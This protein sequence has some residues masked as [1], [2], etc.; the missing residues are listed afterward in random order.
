[1]YERNKKQESTYFGCRDIMLLSASLLNVPPPSPPPLLSFP[2][3]AGWCVLFG[4]PYK[5]DPFNVGQFDSD[6]KYI[7]RYNEICSNKSLDNYPYSVSTVNADG[8]VMRVTRLFKSKDPIQDD[9]TLEDR[10]ALYHCLQQIKEDLKIFLLP[11]F[12]TK[13]RQQCINENLHD[14]NGG[15]TISDVINSM[16]RASLTGDESVIKAIKR[17]KSGLSDRAFVR[18]SVAEFF[19]NHG[20]KASITNSKISAEGSLDIIKLRHRPH[21]EWTGHYYYQVAMLCVSKQLQRKITKRCTEARLRRGR[22][23]TLGTSEATDGDAPL[24]VDNDNQQPSVPFVE[25]MTELRGILRAAT[26]IELLMP[27]VSRLKEVI[28]RFESQSTIAAEPVVEDEEEASPQRCSGTN[29]AMQQLYEAL[30]RPSNQQQAQ[31]APSNDRSVNEGPDDDAS[32]SRDS[33][34]HS[35]EGSSDISETE[36]DAQ[37]LDEVRSKQ[38]SKFEKLTRSA[39]LQT[40][41]PCVPNCIHI[42]TMIRV[43]I[44]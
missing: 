33:D 9:I 29:A 31:T 10:I 13:V 20:I 40:I 27:T 15:E 24:P 43:R 8:L 5:R 22:N 28:D 30:M 38:R 21:P 25:T 1:M 19:K 39:S 2:A 18:A 7:Q 16:A 44:F 32:S 23:E 14:V 42:L 12:E 26:A 36:G 17:V 4:E 6:A 41:A 37:N 11:K 34:V 35:S 3:H